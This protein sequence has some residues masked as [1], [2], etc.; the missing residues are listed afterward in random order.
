MALRALLLR[1]LLGAFLVGG[2]FSPALAQ[3]KKK[4]QMVVRYVA[5]QEDG[6][7]RHMGKPVM[8]LVVEQLEGGRPVDLIVPNRDMNKGGKI[9]PLPQVLDN[10]RSL[11]R[12]DVIKIEL[13]GSK[14]NPYVVSARPYKLKEGETEPNAYVFENTFRKEEGRSTYTAVVLSRFDEHTTLAVQQMRDKDGDMASDAAIISLL[15]KLKTGEVVEAEVKD[16]RIPVLMGLERYTPEQTGKF[17]KLSEHDVEGQ[18]APAVELE[19]EGKTLTLGVGGKMQGKRWVPD[20]RILAAAKK[21]KP[22]APVVFRARDDNGKL[23]LKEI[24][25]APVRKE[26]ADATPRRGSRAAARDGRVGPEGDM[27]PARRPQK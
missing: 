17:V 12:G 20:A 3:E 9:D 1:A 6:A 11:K 14:P 4:T 18:K 24:E 25:P 26:E 16:G 15:Q 22:D 21:I 13:D 5:H 19:R 10:V 7:F 27:Q 8:V 23:W 2:V